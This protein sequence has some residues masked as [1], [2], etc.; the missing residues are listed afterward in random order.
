M[1]CRDGSGS[2]ESTQL[3]TPWG[4]GVWAPEAEELVFLDS[5]AWGL[6][7]I[8]GQGAGREKETR[9]REQKPRGQ[10]IQCL[11]ASDSKGVKNP[12]ETASSKGIT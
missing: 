2:P 11:S 5:M 12:Q 3:S 4:T 6:G 7:C 10:G 8:T 1:K 9:G